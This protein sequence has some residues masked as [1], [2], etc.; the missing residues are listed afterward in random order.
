[1]KELGFE[2][3]KKWKQYKD[4]LTGKM[5]EYNNYTIWTCE[6]LTNYLKRV[7]EKEKNEEELKN[8]H[9]PLFVIF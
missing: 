1:L 4:K 9:R 5:K 2:L 3:Q 6:I 8:T 7:E